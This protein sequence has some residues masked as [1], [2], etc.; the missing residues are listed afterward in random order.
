MPSQ[1]ERA[2]TFSSLHVKGRPL[3]LFNIWDAGSAQVVSRAGAK[4]IATG[5]WSVAAAHGYADGEKLP[6][7]LALANL[8]RVV[9]AVDLPVTLDFEAGYARTPATLV[10][11]AARVLESGA[12]GFNLEDQIIGEGTLFSVT[13][14]V[15]RIR[16]ARSAADRA[17]IPAFINARTDIFL[18]APVETHDGSMLDRA[19]ERAAAYQ[20]AGASGFFAPGLIDE[21]LIA[22]LCDRCALPVNILAMPNAPPASRLAAAGVARISHGP[23]PYRSLLRVLEDAARTVISADQR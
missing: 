22:V 15:A 7:E 4:A 14:Q 19:L 21:G 12:I 16:A 8:Q 23:W 6:L 11:S 10:M 18:K 5:S 1:S 2:T 3:I 20:D 13:E 17:G 9:G